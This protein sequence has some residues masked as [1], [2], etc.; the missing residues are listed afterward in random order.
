MTC[1]IGISGNYII[2]HTGLL[3][4]DARAYVF[5]DYIKAVVRAGGTPFM[6]PMI[7]EEDLIEA[8]IDGV[9]ALILTGGQDVDPQYYDEEPH[10]KLGQTFI[11]RDLFDFKLIECALNKKKPILGVCRGM[12]AL[13][14]FCGGTLYQDLSMRDNTNLK[15]NQ[16]SPLQYGSLTVRIEEESLLH[17]FFGTEELKVNSY[18]HQAVKDLAS[19]FKI[20]ATAFD[21]VI[22]AIE[23]D[24]EPVMGVQW[25]PE[26]MLDAQPEMQK[27][28]N[29]FIQLTK[30]NA[31]A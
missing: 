20:T 1:K 21:G 9:D 25:H 27:L 6:L 12:Q 23:M 3:P 4:G 11:P 19:G 8:Q 31:K 29:G 30:D 26:M 13:N 5:N 15:H 14:V 7:S 10:R 28:F 24:G 17:S 22:E 18:H 2:P 16:T